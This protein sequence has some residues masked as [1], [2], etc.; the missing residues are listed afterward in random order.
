M[1]AQ[2]YKCSTCE[3]K[4]LAFEGDESRL[5]CKCEKGI[6]QKTPPMPTI[7]HASSRYFVDFYLDSITTI[8]DRDQENRR[9]AAEEREIKHF[10]K[11]VIKE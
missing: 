5:F 7:V 1:A 2:I 4:M 6:W 8:H 10:S 9:K 11:A 3:S